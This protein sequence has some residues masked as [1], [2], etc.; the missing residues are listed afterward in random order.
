MSAFFE[1]VGPI[2]FA[3][4]LPKPAVVSAVSGGRFGLKAVQ[5][6]TDVGLGFGAATT[7]WV[8]ELVDP[9][10]GEPIDAVT[11]KP[12]ANPV[13]NPTLLTQANTPISL[14]W[15]N[16]LPAGPHILP[17]DPT[18]LMSMGPNP[19]ANAFLPQLVA[20]L[21]GGH[22]AAIYDGYPNYVKLPGESTTYRYD[23]SQ[24]GSLIWYH[25]HTMGLTRLNVYA[26]LAG[27]YQL[28]DDNHARLVEMGVLPAVL[29]ANDTTLFIADKAF[30]TTGGLYYPAG[31]GD[32][33]P[34]TADTVDSVLPA[35]YATLGG[36]FPTAVP[37]FYGNVITVN[38]V[39]WP[40]LNVAK[41][42]VE[43]ELLNASDSR[44]YI[45]QLDNPYVKVT[46]LG[47]DGGLLQKPVVLINGDG[48]QDPNEQIV[49]APAD[50]YQLL[51]NFDNVPTGTAVHLI[52]TSAAYE[53]FK[54]FAPDGTLAG[55]VVQAT[56]ADPISQIMEFRVDGTLPAFH[57][58]LTPDTVLN[59]GFT[60]IPESAATTTR[61]LGLFE[62][63]DE[64]G[65]IMPV[66]GTAENTVDQFGNQVAAGGLGY[67]TPVTEIVH[68]TNGTGSVTEVWEFYNV[69]ADAHPIHIHQV[70][71][72]VLGRYQLTVNDGTS[73]GDTNGDGVVLRG[74]DNYNNDFGAAIPLEATDEGPQD[75]VWLAPGEGIK[76]IATFD[77]P[78]DY[79]WHCHILSHEDHDMMR[80]FKVIG[81]GGD[82]TGSATENG[83]ATTGL[84]EIGR[85]DPMK[86]GF[87]AGTFTGSA[88][89]GRLTL[90][91]NLVMPDGMAMPADNNGEWS[92]VTTAA[93]DALAQGEHATDVVTISEID[94]T[95][96]AVTIDVVGVNDAPVVAGA[97]SLSGQFAAARLITS[98][99]LLGKSSDV[100]HGAVLAVT[101]LTASAGQLVD[102]GDGTWLYYAVPGS[103]ASV[104]LSYQVSDG[105][106]A[107]AGSATLALTGAALVQ[108][109][110]TAAADK[111]TL[112]GA[113][114]LNG[115]AGNDTLTGSA[116]ADTITGGAGADVISGAAGDDR[117]VAASG[118]GIDSYNGGAGIDTYDLSATTV[119]AA[120]NLALGAS[121]STQAGADLL[122]GIENV[123]GGSANDTLSGDANANRLV[124]LGGN[125]TLVG[126]GGN[127]T[128]IGGAGNDTLNGGAGTN[129]MNGGAGDDIYVVSSAT[130]VVSEAGGSGIDQ[131]QANVTWTLGADIEN[132]GLT[133]TAAI[134]GTGNALANLIVG[135]AAAN[136]LTGGAG[137]DTLSGEAG[138]DTIDGGAGID[139]AVYASATAAVVVNLVTGKATGAAGS[140]TLIGIENVVGGA[141]ADTITGDAG[142]N[143]LNGG[144]GNDVIGGGA[145]DDLLL[146]GL[147]ND[148][149]TGGAGIDTASYETATA[150]VTVN[151]VTGKATGGAGS[152]T[153]AQIENVIGGAG[154]DVITGN[155]GANT[156]LGGAGNDRLISGG[157]ADILAG[158][159][160][161][162]TFVLAAGSATPPVIADF[163]KA[164]GDKIELSLA[165]FAGIGTAGQPLSA[166]A[167]ALGNQALQA[168]DRIIYDHFTGALLY[169][170]DG[171]G[172]G[173]AVLIAQLANHAALTATDFV[174]V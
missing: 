42:D 120:V 125:D 174:L 48:V 164:D 155:A 76:V 139:A 131:V 148:T 103:A 82:F 18:L 78:G 45:L 171:S 29:G 65:R 77:R 14:V 53:P 169:D 52:N 141:G 152:D 3:N 50:R 13:Y 85:A 112:A 135:N 73:A 6:Q 145:G 122:S 7:M 99:E 66:V 59:P 94:G 67:M 151:L 158:G 144:A 2:T 137:D 95:T 163:A 32:V 57:T 86:Q 40:H 166:A 64:F 160:G 119:A 72:Q 70:E 10:T 100:D 21:H 74:E 83:A 104:S 47:V 71:F 173:A 35:D 89:L 37:E 109:N 101:G 46:L 84:M 55:G 38:N 27:G 17:V 31:S 44:I 9:V 129:T 41:G 16:G 142:A 68:L 75:T 147:G 121:A 127:D 36:Q 54:G 22:T 140:D 136:V 24:Q 168:D 138:N 63:A 26:G 124:G 8:Y 105:I 49:F 15:S 165:L 69:T 156:L 143:F 114:V 134:N 96:H 153:L 159:K 167:F 157:G 5:I 28:T 128:L 79:V 170:A 1:Q 51:F 30:T 107:T 43:F 62:Y 110:G 4:D 11:L 106:A 91:G 93:A 97:V 34:G 146:G 154:N 25:D 23:N 113:G 123:T 39:A 132:L 133:G 90:A 98:A 60:P 61:K 80:P 115:L 117:F 102:Q 161:A 111:L 20:H 172:S 92:Y 116:G 118:D 58:T 87:I 149:L 12:T 33:L 130:D 108:V 150:A 162:D 19:A 81:I 56:A 126:A 88:G